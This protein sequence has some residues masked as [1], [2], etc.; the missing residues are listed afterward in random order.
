M[1]GRGVT[2]TGC[3]ALAI[4]W[5][6]CGWG[7]AG[8]IQRCDADGPAYT[9]AL[10]SNSNWWYPMG[11]STWWENGVVSF[12]GPCNGN[13]G[14]TVTKVELWLWVAVPWGWTV[15]VT[16]LVLAAICATAALPPRCPTAHSATTGKWWQRW[17]EE[18]QQQ[19]E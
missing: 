4:K 5:S 3:K 6:D 13:D 15:I 17:R 7:Q 2:A 16:C 9:C 18:K 14:I 12:P 1:L 11:T 19:E 8:G 10:R